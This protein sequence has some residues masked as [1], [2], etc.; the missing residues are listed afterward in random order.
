MAL[1]EV[2]AELENRAAAGG[3]TLAHLDV[4]RNLRHIVKKLDADVIPDLAE[5][6]VLAYNLP[7]ALLIERAMEAMVYTLEEARDRADKGADFA[8]ILFHPVFFH[9]I[10]RTFLHPYQ[11]HVIRD[12]ADKLNLELWTVASI[13]DDVYDIYKRSLGVD[14][15][16]VP[17]ARRWRDPFIDLEELRTILMWRD[18]ELTASKF[19]ATV[20]DVKHLLFHRKGRL[21]TFWRAAIEHRACFYL[22]HAI[23]QVRRDWNDA[24]GSRKCKHPQ[25]ERGDRLV[26]QI[27][28]VADAIGEHV[29]LFEPTCIDEFRLDIDT[30]G[31]LRTSDLADKML[32]P[33]TKRWPIG[34][35]RRLG[36]D[37]E[38]IAPGG[39]YLEIDPNLFAHMLP[40]GAAELPFEEQNAGETEAQYFA[41]LRMTADALR[42][43]MKRQIT[44]RDYALAEQ[45]DI[46]VAVRP[47]SNED[48]AE[49]SGGVGHELDSMTI[50]E[51][52]R[53][54]PKPTI[55][56]IHPD[57]DEAMRRKNVVAD[58]LPAL[59]HEFCAGAL[60][61]DF[62]AAVVDLVVN[63]STDTFPA[64]EVQSLSK[65]H[66][67]PFRPTGKGSTM[68]GVAQSG[69]AFAQAAFLRALSAT[70]IMSTPLIGSTFGDDPIVKFLPSDVG[71]DVIKELRDAEERVAKHNSKHA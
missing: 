11:P 26:E 57:D 30:L 35:A 36:G 3:K 16:F 55:Y 23:S 41:S 5:Q 37:V 50:R 21:D 32:P 12:V 27:Q 25:P 29:A 69:V 10:T 65:K 24:N 4:E 43:E 42:N 14:G 31:T 44:V 58:V 8:L 38:P 56:V 1:E 2:G 20:C 70:E 13:H 18:R 67:V 19:I 54:L 59:W 53:P 49:I 64:Q 34:G 9:Q 63:W 51:R 60:D 47:Y 22:S 7:S 68:D 71:E 48:V 39:G 62:E 17:A 28:T 33:L 40:E 15:V 66:E 61:E 46:I 52:I 45:A 6:K